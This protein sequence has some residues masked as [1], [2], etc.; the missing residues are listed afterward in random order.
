MLRQIL[1]A[2]QNGGHPNFYAPDLV[3]LMHLDLNLAILDLNLAR[4]MLPTEP[5]DYRMKHH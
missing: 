4:L 3:L 2:R 5:T 1:S